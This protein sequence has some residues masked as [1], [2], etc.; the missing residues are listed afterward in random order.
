MKIGLEKIKSHKGVTV[1]TLLDSEAT[2]LFMDKGFA[3]EKRSRMEK[4]RKL[5]MVKN[6]DDT[7]NSGGA[8]TYEVKCNMFF[9]EHIERVKINICN[10]GKTKVI[11][12]MPWLAAQNPEINWEKRKI[13]I[14]CCSPLCGVNLKIKSK[15]KGK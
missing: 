5:V 15:K 6:I 1:E 14:I 4:L 2:G 11:L 8:I 10:L 3:K 12:G 9:K 13:E 7:R